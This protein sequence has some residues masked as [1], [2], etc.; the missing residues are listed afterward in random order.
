MLFNRSWRSVNGVLRV[1]VP[2]AML[3]AV[4]LVLPAGAWGSICT[5]T[6]RRKGVGR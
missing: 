6:W 2:V 5:D 4:A 3:V 1:V